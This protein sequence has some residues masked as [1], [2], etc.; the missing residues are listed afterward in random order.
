MIRLWT[1][2]CFYNFTYKLDSKS[3]QCTGVTEHRFVYMSNV[4]AEFDIKQNAYPTQIYLVQVSMN[5]AN[6]LVH[7]L[8]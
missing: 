3:G 7:G 5:N 1:H 4:R 6:Q 2:V 8:F